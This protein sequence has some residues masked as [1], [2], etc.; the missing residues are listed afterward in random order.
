MPDEEMAIANE[1]IAAWHERLQAITPIGE[2]VEGEWYT[3]TTRSCPD[4]GWQIGAFTE[5]GHAKGMAEHKCV[6]EAE[7]A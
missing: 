3:G 6:K 4:C 5:A 2:A 1:K 7:D